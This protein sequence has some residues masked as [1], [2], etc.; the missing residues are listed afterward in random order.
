MSGPLRSKQGCWTCRLRK[1]KCD[2]AHPQCSTCESLSITCYGYGSK[3]EWMDGGE[4]ERVMA[5]SIKQIVKHT[6]RR[7]GTSRLGISGKRFLNHQ[8]V[9]SKE[10]PL[11]QIAPKSRN[12]SPE[13]PSSSSPGSTTDFN[14]TPP[15]DTSK[16]SA[17]LEE[18]AHLTVTT[19]SSISGNDCVLLMHFLDN[20]FPLQYPMY[21]PNLREGGRGWLLSLLLR[22]KPLYHA[23]LALSVYHRR[24]LLLMLEPPHP[25]HAARL[26]EQENHLAICLTEFQ[27]TIRSVQQFVERTCP[28]NVMGIMAS[29]VQLVFFELFA[30]HGDTWQIHLRAAT[31]MFEQGCNEQMSGFGLGERANKVLTMNLPLTEADF[32]IA[33]EVS[34]I[35]FQGCAT[36]WLDI[37]TS[38]TLGTSPHLQA[39][40]HRVI[41]TASQ[42]KMENVMG[43]ENWVMLQIARISALHEQKTEALKAG[44]LDPI[45]FD[46]SAQDIRSEIE[47]GVTERALESFNMSECSLL[48]PSDTVLITKMFTYMASIYLHLVIYG[49]QNLDRLDTILSEAAALIRAHI[50]CRLLPGFVCPLFFLA[51]VARPEDKP[52][53]RH[54]FSSAPLLDPLLE[55]RNIASFGKFADSWKKPDPLNGQKVAECS[56]YTPLI[57]AKYMA[58]S[59]LLPKMSYILRI[60]A[61][62]TQKALS[63]IFSFLTGGYFNEITDP[64]LALRTMKTIVILGGSFGGISTAHR[65]LKQS[66]KTGPVKIILVTPNTHMYFNIATPRAIVSGQFADSQIFEPIAAGFKQYSDS[67]FE[68]ILATAES[69]DIENKKVNITSESGSRALSYDILIL[70]T[71]SS[72]KGDAPFK[73]RGST[74][75]TKDALHDFQARAKKANSIVIGGAGT[76][77]VEAAGELGFEY[78]L[79]KKIIL[80][81]SGPTILEPTPPSVQ[82]TATK[83]L[84]ALKVEIKLSTKIMGVAKTPD[85]REELT[86]S[87]GEKLTTDL[88]LPALGIKP[89]SSYVPANLLNGNGFVIVDEFLHVKGFKDIWA[90]GDIS[91]VEKAKSMYT[92]KQSA[93]VAKN[94][95]LLLSNKPLLPYKPDP[96]EINAV[97]IGRKAGTGH[98]GNIKLPSFMVVMIKGKLYF[99]DKMAPMVNGTSA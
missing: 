82:K 87:S 29:V 68:F 5:N 84:Q 23:A 53:F 90:V 60:A 64:T 21:K 33:D 54:F 1:K 20:V 77:G 36:I 58:I 73:G 6:S 7:K 70:A 32:A 35:R 18:A 55:H 34:I 94:I 72:Q 26:V 43:C 14:S 97:P 17:S 62:A 80:I 65:I 74:E 10:P 98:M 37:I 61:S 96:K 28:R 39:F 69:L 31:A 3:P 11:I 27:E 50:S 88:Y 19:L 40:H 95:A 38:I 25:C 42:I 9:Q 71:G 92:D 44:Y 47:Q 24:R 99:S 30:G 41:S 46:Q 79:S 22:T 57:I 91:A 59:H 12:D 56:F 81:A 93:H 52:L 66:A 49:Y 67:Q 4:K 63:I 86:L 8:P 45:K 2:E 85:G 13:H 51:S 76:T 89:N 83:Q 75:A 16:S 78:G 48:H 15:S